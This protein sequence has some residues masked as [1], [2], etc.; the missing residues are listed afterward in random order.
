MFAMAMNFEIRTSFG[1]S[2]WASWY[3]FR[4]SSYIC[5][6][7]NAFPSRMRCLASNLLQPTAAT[8]RIPRVAAPRSRRVRSR[9]VSFCRLA[10]DMGVISGPL[11]SP[12]KPS[13][14]RLDPWTRISVPVRRA[15][16]TDQGKT[17]SG[18]LRG[19]LSRGRRGDDASGHHELDPFLHG[20][21][22]V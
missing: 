20:E 10:V 15:D 6:L 11:L 12:L 2:F 8:Q 4:A 13:P 1:S 9:L 19:D 5:S 21:P 14:E 16:G 22:G 3:F 7:K 17:R 18:S